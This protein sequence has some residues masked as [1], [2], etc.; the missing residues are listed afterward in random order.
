MEEHIDIVDSNGKPIG[1]SV[2]KSE[3][4]AKGHLHNTAHIWFFTS[5]GKILLQ[6][7]AASK[8]IYPLLWDVSVA[9]HINAGETP[10]QAAIREAKEEIGLDIS[11]EKLIK[12]GVFE[13]FQS[14]PNGITDNEFHNTFIALIS[15]PISNMTLQKEEVEA[16]KY[17]SINQFYELL[18][19]SKTNNHF[20]HSNRNYYEFVVKSIATKITN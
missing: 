1:I 4:H 15:N 18:K 10:K 16:V 17:V 19:N 6:Q 5:D 14:Y 20:V 8:A 7:R 11:E 3:I 12:I 9:G 2:S 13:C